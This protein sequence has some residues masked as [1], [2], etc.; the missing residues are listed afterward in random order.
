M[1]KGTCNYCE[2]TYIRETARL[3]E[4]QISERLNPNKEPPSAVQEHLCE[5]YHNMYIDSFVAL[6]SE[7]KEVHR[8]F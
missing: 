5:K 1:Y 2:K 7:S 6:K 8:K 4:T 3:L